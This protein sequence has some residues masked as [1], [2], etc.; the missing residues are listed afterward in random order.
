M[1]LLPTLLGICGIPAPTGLE[2]IDL[3]DQEAVTKRTAIFGA[4]YTHDAI[5]LEVAA[6]NLRWRWCIADGWKLIVPDAVN[7]P[8][9]VVQ[10]FHIE[11]DPQEADDQATKDPAR[12]AALRTLMDGWWN[13]RTP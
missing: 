11:Q 12:V 3:R 2:G 5:D 4:C 10:L 9:S 8:K 7:E 1:D 13:G 6:R